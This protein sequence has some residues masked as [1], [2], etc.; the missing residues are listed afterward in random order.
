ML[1]PVPLEPDPLSAS[2]AIG[3]ACGITWEVGGCESLFSLPQTEEN[4]GSSEDFNIE[5]L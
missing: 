2:E 5:L 3:S 4:G 1:F